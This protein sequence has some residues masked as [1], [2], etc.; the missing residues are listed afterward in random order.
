MKEQVAA[1]ARRTG[2]LLF[3]TALIAA[4]ASDPNASRAM[5]DHAEQKKQVQKE[6]EFAK[7]LPPTQA[8]PVYR[9]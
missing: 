2:I 3:A 1:G 9:E 5:Q 4:C 6:Q 7:T 8:K